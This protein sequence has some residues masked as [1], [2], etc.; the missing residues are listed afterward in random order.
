MRHTASIFIGQDIK[1]FTAQLGKYV[2]KYG[3]ADAASYFTSMI[4]I[5]DEDGKNFVDMYN[6]KA[7]IISVGGSMYLVKETTY[8]SDK[9]EYTLVISDTLKYT[10]KISNGKAIF[11][12]VVEEN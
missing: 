5:H 9:D 7:S 10:L 8:D 11:T 3:E 1:A 6:N 2:L 12:K 4:W